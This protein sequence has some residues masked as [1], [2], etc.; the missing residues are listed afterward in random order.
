MT[1]GLWVLMVVACVT[2]LILA[3]W[4]VAALFP[5]YPRPQHRWRPKRS[6][7]KERIGP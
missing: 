1:L 2:I 7:A 4:V 6:R 5:I 3:I